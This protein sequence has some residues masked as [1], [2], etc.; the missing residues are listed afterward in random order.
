MN[1]IAFVISIFTSRTIIL[2]FST[3][4][5]I[6]AV[7]MMLNIVTVD[8]LVVILKLSPEAEKALRVIVERFQ[9][10]THNIL[11]IL[12]QLLNKLFGWAGIDAD[13]SKIKVDLNESSQSTSG[14][15]KNGN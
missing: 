1:P 14:N 6:L 2:L 4:F 15:I 7:M 5:S 11:D 3:T 12:S 13:L 8:D 9:E 10:V